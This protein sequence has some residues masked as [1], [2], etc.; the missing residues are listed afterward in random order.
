MLLLQVLDGRKATGGKL[1]VRVKIREP[2]GGV[3]LQSVTE[4]WLVIDP[5]TPSPEKERKREKEREQE[6]SKEKERVRDHNWWYFYYTQN[7]ILCIMTET[8]KTF[9]FQQAPSPRSKPQNDHDRNFKP[10]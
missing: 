10:R 6:K 9:S 5:L 8:H 7:V 1:E 4:K 3:Q 2:L